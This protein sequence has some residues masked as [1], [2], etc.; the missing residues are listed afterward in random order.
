MEFAKKAST[1]LSAM[2]LYLIIPIVFLF[3]SDSESD[4]FGILLLVI[5][6]ICFVLFLVIGI[7]NIVSAAGL[8]KIGNY[9]KIRS[10]MMKLKL[11]SIPFFLA[12]YIIFAFV[13]VTFSLLAVFFFWT[14][15]GPV[16]LMIMVALAAIILYAAVLISSAYGI[17]FVSLLRKE[18]V[19]S[20]GLLIFYIVL[21]LIPVADIVVTIVLLS[22]Y[23]K[24][25]I[26]KV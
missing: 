26:S 20:T 24:R 17:A 21:Q 18:K 19:I 8:F 22:N 6:W 2:Y 23:K 4:T 13:A 16:A 12:E 9:D 14:I 25:I 7:F 3:L 10:E 11:G 1:L 5:C 15:G